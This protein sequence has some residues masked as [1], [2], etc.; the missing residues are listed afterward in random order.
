MVIMPVLRAPPTIWA[1]SRRD[2]HLLTQSD[3]LFANGNKEADERLMPSRLN[4]I[5]DQALCPQRLKVRL[6]VPVGP[7][8]S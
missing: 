8:R 4:P 6:G 5:V 3:S 2:F 1:L 7:P